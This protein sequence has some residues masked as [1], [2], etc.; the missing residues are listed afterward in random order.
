MTLKKTS[1]NRKDIRTA[2]YGVPLQHRHFAFIA[3]TIAAMPDHA[4]TLK[5]QKASVASTFADACRGTNPHFDRSRFL[6]ACKLED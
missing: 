4:A 1:A 6:A 2:Q 3:A 5:A